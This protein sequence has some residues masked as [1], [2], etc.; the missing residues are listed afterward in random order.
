M[1]YCHY[2]KVVSVGVE[3]SIHRLQTGYFTIRRGIAATRFP[4]FPTC[5]LFIGRVQVLGYCTA[6]VQRGRKLSQFTDLPV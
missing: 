1:I 2:K 6:T 5:Y 4:F 3:Y